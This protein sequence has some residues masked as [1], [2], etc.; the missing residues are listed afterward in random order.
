M[1]VRNHNSMFFAA[2]L[3]AS[4]WSAQAA[5]IRVRSQASVSQGIVR[6][7][8]I[9]DVITQDETEARL[10]EGIA[11][12]PAPDVE[13]TRVI[14]RQELQQ[15]LN[16]SGIKLR[17]HRFGGAE[18]TQVQ[19]SAAQPV[20][21]NTI[22]ANRVAANYDTIA[23]VAVAKPAFAQAAEQAVSP[24]QSEATVK[25]KVTAAVI[26]HLQVVS[27]VQAEWQ[28]EVAFSP[29]VAKTLASESILKVEGGVS[30]WTGRQQF[31]LHVGNPAAPTRLPIEVEIAGTV[32][33][34]T[35]SRL[36]EKGMVLSADDLQLQTVALKSGVTLVFDPTLLI[37]R[38]TTRTLNPGQLLSQ[39]HA[40]SIRL[41]KR[42]EDIQVFSIGAG[43]QIVEP[44]KA[45]ADGSQGDSITVEFA[46]RRKM[47][48]RVNGIRR[49]EVYAMQTSRSQVEATSQLIRR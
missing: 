40:R 20:A 31:V 27:D 13:G 33:A 5:D 35:A 47:T 44:A 34:V 39:E 16:L 42:G 15:L 11:L 24:E 32:R 25:G 28:A 10:L 17:E 38:E 26:A 3:V 4:Q 37:G 23:E 8:D 9:A 41:V 36:V 48:A 18:A 1:S 2:V 45:L 30:P 22:V 12:V 29:R 14:K 43:L 7:G 46:D 19:S 21:A 6:L 49:A